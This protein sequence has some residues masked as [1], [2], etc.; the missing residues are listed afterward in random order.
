MNVFFNSN[1]FAQDRIFSLYDTDAEEVRY[2]LSSIVF[3][4]PGVRPTP[5]HVS[6]SVCGLWVPCN[7]KDSWA[8]WKKCVF[9]ANHLLLSGLQ[10]CLFLDLVIGMFQYLDLFFGMIKLLY[11]VFSKRLPSNLVFGMF[12]SLDPSIPEHVASLGSLL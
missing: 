12:Q 3:V 9:H 7:V 4:T 10:I 8:I 11:L 1:Y 6:Y 5:A 2:K